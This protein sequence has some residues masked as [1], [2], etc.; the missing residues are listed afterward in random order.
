MKVLIVDDEIL[1]R[2]VIK[3]YLKN[4]NIE[5]DEAE[6]GNIAIELSK[7]NNYDCI[8]MDNHCANHRVGRC[9]KFTIASEL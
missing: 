3:E 7:L 5:Y 1:I 8:I 6:D 4:D 2:N 9:V